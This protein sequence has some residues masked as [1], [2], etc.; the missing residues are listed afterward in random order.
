MAHKIKNFSN[1][2]TLAIAAADY[3][4]A[5]GLAAI[6]KNGRF[7]VALSGGSTPNILYQVLVQPAYQSKI[8]WKKTFIFWSDERCVPANDPQNNSYQAYQVL[9][10]EVPIPKE[11]IFTIPVHLTPAAA[12]AAYQLTIQQFFKN[13][14]PVF[15]IVLL[16][17]GDNGH[18]ASL[19]PHT[20]ILHETTALVKNIYVNEVN[21]DRITFT[22]PFINNAQHRLF[23]VTG[24][25]KKT[26]LQ[27]VLHGNYEPDNY[28]AQLIK[29]AD[30]YT[31]V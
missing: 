21:M 31:C 13:N 7:C 23:L 27:K 11:N 29:N 24:A 14:F 2:N 16:G 1:T 28:P 25:N 12:A 17:M 15:D 20:S 9:L 19:F 26:M 5:A 3:I 30:W 10:N 6:K 18:T 22:A 8:D 4:I